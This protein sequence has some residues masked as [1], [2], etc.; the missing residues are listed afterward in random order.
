MSDIDDEIDRLYQGPLEAFTEARN[1]L[2]KSAKRADLKTLQ[3]P[4]L[5]AWVVNQLHWHR[6]PVIDR[7]VAAAEAVRLEHGKALTGKNADVRAAEQAHRDLVKDGL[8]AAREVLAEGGHPATPATLDAIRETLQALPSPE[9]NGRLTRALSPRGFEALA[10]LTVT[11]PARPAM[12]V[13]PPPKR[14][15]RTAGTSRASDA[16]A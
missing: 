10:G 11:A 15:D 16:V 5:P 12:H 9:A 2:A 13:V 1:A 3:K 14:H 6:R 8:A 7:L 4:N